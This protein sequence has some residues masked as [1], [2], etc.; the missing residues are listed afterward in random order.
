QVLADAVGVAD[1]VFLL[2]DAGEGEQHQA[3]V[4]ALGVDPAAGGGEPPG[5]RGRPRPPGETRSLYGVGRG[6][7]GGVARAVVAAAARMTDVL[8][9]GADLDAGPDRPLLDAGAGLLILELAVDDGVADDVLQAAGEDVLAVRRH[10]RVEVAQV[11]P[12][13]GVRRD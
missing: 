5:L 1:L 12:F 2:L 10:D 13:H 11:D 9:I 6:D 7:V 8:G 3:L 4:A